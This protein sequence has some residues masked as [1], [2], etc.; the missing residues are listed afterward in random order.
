MDGDGSRPTRFPI[1]SLLRVVLVLVAL[2]S[3]LES[4]LL[5]RG[6]LARLLAASLAL[7]TYPEQL[8]LAR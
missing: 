3:D 5:A 8:L 6:E 1:E 4:A 7:R 2:G